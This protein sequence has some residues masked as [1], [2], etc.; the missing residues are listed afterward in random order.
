MANSRKSNP[1]ATQ[2]AKHPARRQSLNS[3]R[4]FGAPER[5]YARERE[6][7]REREP[8]VVP[9]SEKHPQAGSAVGS[10]AC[11]ANKATQNEKTTTT[12]RV[13]AIKLTRRWA[14]GRTR[15]GSKSKS[16]WVSFAAHGIGIGQ[17]NGLRVSL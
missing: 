7:E 9:V 12:R 13:R 17:F 11:V 2:P 8:K 10:G 6:R 14:P 16:G 3:N 15:M 5:N 1:S 4:C